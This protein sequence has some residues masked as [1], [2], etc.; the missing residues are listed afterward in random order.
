MDFFY[1]GRRLRVTIE[2]GEARFHLRDL[3]AIFG[4]R[5]LTDTLSDAA[6]RADPE[7]TRSE[8]RMYDLLRTSRRP[9]FNPFYRWL[10]SEVS[11]ALEAEGAPLDGE[12]VER[13]TNRELAEE[14]RPL[15]KSRWEEEAVE[16]G[17]GPE[18][19]GVMRSA[20][21]GRAVYYQGRGGARHWGSPR[22]LS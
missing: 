11:P 19:E 14:L 1:K 17:S 16:A 10:M 6:E 13:G 15:W 8:E 20:P 22:S 3:T 21:A 2:E 18:I 5:R 12:P 4:I 7:A 9:G